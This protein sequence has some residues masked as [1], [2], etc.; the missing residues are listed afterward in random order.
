MTSKRCTESWSSG[1]SNE[2]YDDKLFFSDGVTLERAEFCELN[3]TH[4]I[5]VQA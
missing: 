2:L 5:C 3:C 1:Q 4:L